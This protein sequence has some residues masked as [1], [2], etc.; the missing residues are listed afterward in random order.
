MLLS[1]NAR[2][3]YE[4]PSDPAK[5]VLTG[6]RAI[7]NKLQDHRDLELALIKKAFEVADGG[8]VDVEARYHFEVVEQPWKE[9]IKAKI[10]DSDV[11]EAEYTEVVEIASQAS[12][13]ENV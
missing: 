3:S 1:C 8:R 2:Y 5:I 11:I 10:P 7:Y 9:R 4:T 6:S 12:L 13:P